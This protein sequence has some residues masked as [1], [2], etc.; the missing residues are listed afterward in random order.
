MLLR[1]RNAFYFRFLKYGQN[2]IYKQGILIN[3]DGNYQTTGLKKWLTL[4]IPI[5]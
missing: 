3:W 5:L 1:S 4:W 2:Y